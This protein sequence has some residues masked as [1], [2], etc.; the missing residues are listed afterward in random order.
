MSEAA[1]KSSKDRRTLLYLCFLFVPIFL[2]V[3]VIRSS[4]FPLGETLEKETFV[5]TTA[6]AFA[7]SQLLGSFSSLK[8]TLYHLS[9]I[10]SNPCALLPCD[11]VK[12]LKKITFSNSLDWPAS[13]LPF[14]LPIGINL[15]IDFGAL[16][17][18]P[19]AFWTGQS[20]FTFS[21]MNVGKAPPCVPTWRGHVE[22]TKDALIIF[23]ACFQG[24]L[25]HCFRRPHDRERAQL[26][27]SGN[28]FVYEEAT[29]GIK[30]WT[31]GVPWSPSR[32]LTNFLIYRQLNSPFPPGEKK[33]ATKRSQRVPRPGEPY[34]TAAS[35]TSTKDEYPSSFSPESPGLKSDEGADK[36]GDRG[37]VGSLV[38]S[39]EFKDKGLLKKTM[40]VTIKGVQHHLVS[41]YSLEDAKSKLR[42]PRDDD[43]VKNLTL[44]PELLQQPKFK[45]Q[46]LDDAGDGT[47]EQAEVQHQSFSYPPNNFDLTRPYPV[48]GHGLPNHGHVPFFDPSQQYYYA[49][50]SPYLTPAQTPNV[51]PYGSI[52]S[53]SAN[54]APTASTSASTYP[55]T[56]HNFTGSQYNSQ[57]PPSHPQYQPHHQSRYQV[58]QQQQ[59]VPSP[60]GQQMQ[61]LS[62]QQYS[63]STTLPRPNGFNNN[64]SAVQE[65]NGV[66]PSPIESYSPATTPMNPAMM[67]PGMS[68]M[69]GAYMASS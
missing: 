47:Y 48:Q 51:V 16:Q 57:I 24:T 63:S 27:V 44:R 60:R 17:P 59:H 43:Q 22:T 7:E 45:F 23:E 39:Y 12:V 25:A 2:N 34:P 33:R 65:S 36:D 4:L 13:R 35:S 62:L 50:I 41:Y 38:D 64:G 11:D 66:H 32:I 5:P 67:Y 61:P 40:T 1:S 49:N 42:T 55:G 21:V 46:N 30:R 19:Q 8:F 28:V 53:S 56:Q 10:P 3:R 54:Y 14:R 58:L 31:D 15:D 20:Q 6:S 68:Q 52:A 37:L 69:P 18:F 29:S 9:I 26:I